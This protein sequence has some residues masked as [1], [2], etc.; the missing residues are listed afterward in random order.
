MPS[1]TVS[2]LHMNRM[3]CTNQA[4]AWMIA[5]FK[6]KRFGAGKL[7]CT[8]GFGDA[9]IGI[10]T[11][12]ARKLKRLARSKVKLTIKSQ[13]Q[14]RSKVV[15]LRFGDHNYQPPPPLPVP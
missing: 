7:Y 6:N 3:P 15:R 14:L 13:G 12:V 2:L 10:K 1:P 9:T 5:Y 8:D 4:P 11:K